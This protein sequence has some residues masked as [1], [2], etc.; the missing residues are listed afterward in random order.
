MAE[1]FEVINTD[2]VEQTFH[3][4]AMP[5][6]LLNCLVLYVPGDLGLPEIFQF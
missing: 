5:F 4:P 6:A 1:V 3:F 2:T